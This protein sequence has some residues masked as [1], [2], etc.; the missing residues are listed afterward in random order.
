M[1]EF[2]PA[3]KN[4]LERIFEVYKCAINEMN[5]H[6][7]FQWDE[8]YPD[9]NILYDDICKNQLYICVYKDEIVSAYVLN[10]ESDEQYKNG[11]WEFPNASYRVIHRLCVNPEFQNQGIGTLTVR[12]IEKTLKE[13]G[14]ETIRLDCFTKNQYAVR[15]YEKLNYNKIGFANWGKGKF[16]LMEKKL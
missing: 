14:I 12:Y 5:K 1:F 15:M 9:K 8:I 11:N 6:S 7:I 4:D 10:R 16:F 2:K 13:N 3:N